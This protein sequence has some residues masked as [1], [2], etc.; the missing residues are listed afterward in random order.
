MVAPILSVVVAGNIPLPHSFMNVILPILSLL[1]G[2]M[3]TEAASGVSD[4]GYP[5]PG[6]VQELWFGIPGASVKDLTHGKIF[7]TAA[8]AVHTVSSLDVENLGD[9]YGARYSALLRVPVS[10]KYRLY[11]SSDDSA[12]LW[13]GKDAT[14]KDM[15]CIATVKGYS[16]PHNW[17]NQPNQASE[18]VQLEA[19]RFYFL[20]V[21]HKEDGGPDHMSVA[22][23]GPDIP[24]PVIIPST[25][26]FVPPGVLPEDKPQPP[27]AAD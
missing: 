7:D 15:A 12:E 21:I 18:P 23:S 25:A 4:A 9:Q 3:L 6:V 19:G 8:S 17:S 20:V 24:S 14:Q 5:S 22:W 11:L 27:A 2:A 16:D 10:G 13:L 26:L 1:C